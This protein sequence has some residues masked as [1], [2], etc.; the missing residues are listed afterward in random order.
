MKNDNITKGVLC[1]V[2]S[3]LAFAFMGAFVKLA[4]DI[5]TFQK[6]FFRNSVSM[7][8][9]LVMIR[10]IGFKNIPLFGH[11]GNRGMLILRSI[12]GVSGVGLNFWAINHLFLTDSTMLNKISPFF[13]TI[14][15][16]LF[17]REKMSKLQIPAT[18]IVFLGAL[19]IIKPEFS[20]D[21]LPALAGFGGA[22]AAGAAY[23]IIRFLK[24]KEEPATIIFFF[25][26]FSVV[27]TFPIMMIQGFV[28]PT[29]AQWFYLIMIG[30]SASFG[31]FG[32][33]TAYKYA[34]AAEVSIYNYTS[35]IF[36]TL[37]G[38]FILDKE[39]PDIWTIIGSVIIVGVA[40]LIFIYNHKRNRQL[41][42]S[43]QSPSRS[44][45]TVSS[46]Q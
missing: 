37:I 8:V 15:A 1:M 36:A 45:G 24:G 14:F 2:G 17:L 10:K 18:I 41:A 19:L 4:G 40:V 35:V 22:A 42:V 46:K 5:P 7:I 20:M 32:V 29:A 30:V 34:P 43:R 11:K 39:I 12:M 28:P 25:S 21:V 6:V 27:S 9:A 13:V 33:T 23:T 38:Y 26:L 44:C 16:W 3:G 31:Q